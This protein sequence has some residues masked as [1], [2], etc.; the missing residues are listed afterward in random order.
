MSID[1]DVP[2]SD[3]QPALVAFAPDVDLVEE[4]VSTTETHS[5]I[6]SENYISEG[7][8]AFATA[9]R[10]HHFR[11]TNVEDAAVGKHVNVDSILPG[12]ISFSNRTLRP[13]VASG[14]D[15]Y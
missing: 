2:V 3:E 8:A 15:T 5:V 6:L 4:P 9:I 1:S 10:L 12:L 7:T 14:E 13:L 11:A